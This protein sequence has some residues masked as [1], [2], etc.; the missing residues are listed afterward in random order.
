MWSRVNPSKVEWN[1]KANTFVNSTAEYAV[2]LQRLADDGFHLDSNV[3]ASPDIRYDVGLPVA[4]SSFWDILVKLQNPEPSCT[5]LFQGSKTSGGCEGFQE[6]V[7]ID[8]AGTGLQRQRVQDFTFDCT[9]ALA[10]LDGQQ[11]DGLVQEVNETRL[12]FGFSWLVGLLPWS[13]Y[14]LLTSMLGSVIS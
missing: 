3:F 8:L 5:S 9:R 7:K 6:V 2:E 13:P 1:L 11:F 14:A 12:G 10:I 4:D